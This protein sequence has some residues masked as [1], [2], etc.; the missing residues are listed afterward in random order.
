MRYG[1]PAGAAAAHCISHVA[2]RRA[3]GPVALFCIHVPSG[4]LGTASRALPS[5]PSFRTRGIWP[6]SLPQPRT[7]DFRARRRCILTRG[8]HLLQRRLPSWPSPSSRPPLP[9]PLH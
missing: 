6:P 9:P 8:A 3:A 2:L 5:L 4:A 1:P 7:L